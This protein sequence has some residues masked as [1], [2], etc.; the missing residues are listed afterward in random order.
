MDRGLARDLPASRECM[1][2]HNEEASRETQG[3]FTTDKTTDPRYEW[4]EVWPG[5]FQLQEAMWWKI[6]QEVM[7]EYHDLLVRLAKC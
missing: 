4:V 5:T 3:G 6:A 7:L 2:Y 1:V